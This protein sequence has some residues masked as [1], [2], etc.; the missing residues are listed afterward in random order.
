MKKLLL[1]PL[2]FALSS[3]V[4]CQLR[5]ENLS[6]LILSPDLAAELSNKNAYSKLKAIGKDFCETKN[7]EQGGGES[8]EHVKESGEQEEESG[9]MTD[10]AKWEIMKLDKR[11]Y[12]LEI[13][14][15]C[16]G[17]MGCTDDYLVDTEQNL[18]IYYLGNSNRF[19]DGFHF[20]QKLGEGNY[21]FYVKGTMA[22][23]GRYSAYTTL[24]IMD[25]NLGMKKT[26]ILLGSHFLDPSESNKDDVIWNQITGEDGL[27]HEDIIE[28]WIF[29]WD[30]IN[31]IKKKRF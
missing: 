15:R 25:I 8:E 30:G 17:A 13:S 26:R 28:S 4:F 20:F 23:N 31:W 16:N 22:I 24:T 11:C 18:K 14:Y 29:H 19:G 9:D 7:E 27:T 10:K 12:M 3:T 1:M 21:R 2:F 5:V 6:S